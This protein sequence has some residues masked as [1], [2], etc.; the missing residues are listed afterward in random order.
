[1]RRGELPPLTWADICDEDGYISIHR[2]QISVKA[3]GSGKGDGFRIVGHTKTYKDR[4]FPITSDVRDC[5]DRIKSVHDRRYPD[6]QFLFPADTA[7][8]CITNNVVYLHYRRVC[9]NL[10]I[11][12][13]S[14]VIKGTHSFRRITHV[15]NSP[16]GGAT[17]ASQLYGNTPE[18]TEANYYAGLDLKAARRVLE[19]T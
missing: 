5:L 15:M 19:S 17:M 8:G 12:T 3:N 13:D 2:E 1:M 7:E 9:D 4:R 16:G 6:S 11:K 14:G 18:V 10:G